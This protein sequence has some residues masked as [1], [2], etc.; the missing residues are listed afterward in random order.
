MRGVP[1]WKQCASI[2]DTVPLIGCRTRRSLRPWDSCRRERETRQKWE[3]KSVKIKSW[4]DAPK[5]RIF[6]NPLH[7]LFRGMPEK[8]L[9][10]QRASKHLS[11][12]ASNFDRGSC[13]SEGDA[14]NCKFP[15]APKVRVQAC[16]KFCLP[17]PASVQ[18]PAP[19]GGLIGQASVRISA[20]LL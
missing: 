14:R 19:A 10:S 5:L 16:C 20:D 9:Q 4:T 7:I 2:T 8:V 13:W 12:F 15:P 3:W 17:F 18:A 6:A 1:M 11:A